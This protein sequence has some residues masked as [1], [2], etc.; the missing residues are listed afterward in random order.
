MPGS[1]TTPG[2][3]GARDDAPGCV[4][5]RQMHGVGTQKRTLSRASRPAESHRRPLSEPSV[6]VSPHWA[7]IRPTSRV[8]RVSSVRKGHSILEIIER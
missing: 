6:R 3:P 4:A 8:V 5:F 2:R 7:P 1:L